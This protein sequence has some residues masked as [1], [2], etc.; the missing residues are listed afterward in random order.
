MNPPK[1][2]LRNLTEEEDRLTGG[3]YAKFETYP[4]ELRPAEGMFWTA[5]SLELAGVK[6]E[7]RT[8]SVPPAPS[9]P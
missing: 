3:K 2:P 8:G 6:I 9:S 7:P 4:D 5:K 1:Y